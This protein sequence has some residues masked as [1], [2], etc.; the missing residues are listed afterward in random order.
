MITAEHSYFNF[1]MEYR[2]ARRVRI[3]FAQVVGVMPEKRTPVD[4]ACLFSLQG[5]K[6]KRLAAN[7]RR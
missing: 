7:L 5:E 1:L 6:R 4:R 2:R 3:P